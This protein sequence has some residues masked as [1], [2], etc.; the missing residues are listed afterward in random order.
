LTNSLAAN[1]QVTV[2][3][4]TSGYFPTSDE[5]LYYN[6]NAISKF[7]NAAPGTPFTNI[8]KYDSG[9]MITFDS[10]RVTFDSTQVTF[11]RR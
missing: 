6:N 9:E 8:V 7:L 2:I 4:R 11:D 1:T 5:D 10:D 3:K